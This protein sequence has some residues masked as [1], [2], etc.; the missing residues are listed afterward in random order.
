[1][2]DLHIHS[3]VSDGELTPSQIIDKACQLKLNAISITD[4]D[5]VGGL[6]EAIEYSRTKNIEVIPGIELDTSIKYGKM[7][8]LGYYIDYNSTELKKILNIIK[9][10]RDRRNKR[11][12]DCFNKLGINITLDEVR[13][14]SVRTNTRQAT[15]CKGTI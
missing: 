3:T 6:Q 13:K 10:D 15:F 5:T 9:K 4:H 11:F 2:I 1:M 14:H 8:I 7:H 12:I